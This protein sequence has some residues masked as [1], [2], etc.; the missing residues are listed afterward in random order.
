[1]KYGEHNI[2]S[3]A[4]RLHHSEDLVNASPYAVVLHTA[5]TLSSRRPGARR[6]VMETYLNRL[7]DME[8]VVSGFGR[9]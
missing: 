8:K 4:I 3:D 6:E 9:R 1:M 7:Q 5:N 2:V